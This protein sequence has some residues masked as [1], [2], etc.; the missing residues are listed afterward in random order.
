M[1]LF[2]AGCGLA[3]VGFCALVASPL[4]FFMPLRWWVLVLIPTV[5]VGVAVADRVYHNRDHYQFRFSYRNRIDWVTLPGLLI[6]LYCSFAYWFG[7]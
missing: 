5:N 6:I 3:A 2:A 1:T 7:F 4:L